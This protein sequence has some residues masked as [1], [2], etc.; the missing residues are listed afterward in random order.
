M[1]LRTN[2]ISDLSYLLINQDIH[3]LNLFVDMPAVSEVAN[4]FFADFLSSFFL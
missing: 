4:D 3:N 1:R 2:Y